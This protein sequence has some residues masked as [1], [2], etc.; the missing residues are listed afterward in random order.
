MNV[1]TSYKNEV[2]TEEVNKIALSVDDDK[3]IYWR[4]V[5]TLWRS[6]IIDRLERL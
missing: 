2:Y 5:Y 1:I 3:D 4:M 6:V